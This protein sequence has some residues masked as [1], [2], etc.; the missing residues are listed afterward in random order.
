MG[1]TKRLGAVMLPALAIALFVA[2]LLV[3]TPAK[4][5]RA[6]TT[7]FENFI[8]TDDAEIQSGNPTATS[9]G[10]TYNIYNGYRILENG[11]IRIY[12]KFD[13]SKI[14]SSATIN[15]AVLKLISKYGP[16]RE[17]GFTDT[18]H[19]VDA[20]PVT[21]DSWSESTIAWD[22]APSPDLGTI[23]DSDYFQADGFL[24]GSTDRGQNSTTGQYAWYTW[25][26]KSFVAS[27]IASGDG[28]ITICLKRHDVEDA[29]ESYGW[30]YSKDSG[31]GY[32]DWLPRI[33]VSWKSDVAVSIT[34]ETHTFTTPGST[35][36][37]TVTVKNDTG[38][39]ANFNLTVENK[40]VT[41]IPSTTGNIP[42]GG[43]ADVTLTVKCPIAF[44]YQDTITV[45]ATCI[46]H[47]EFTASDTCTAVAP[48]L[49]TEADAYVIKQS[50][51]TNVGYAKTVT[52]GTE[53]SGGTMQDC[54]GYWK[55]NLSDIPNGATIDNAYFEVYTIYGG[56]NGGY[57]TGNPAVDYGDA[58]LTVTLKEVTDD[59]DEASITWNNKPDMGISLGSVVVPPTNARWYSWNVTSFVASQFSSEYNAVSFGMVSESEGINAFVPWTAKDD[60]DHWEGQQSQLIIQYTPPPGGVNVSISPLSKRGQPGSTLTYT[61]TVKNTGGGSDTYALAASDSAGWSPS[62][63]PTSTGSL[64]P[65]AQFTAT[66]S[67]PIPSD[68]QNGASHTVR[69][70]AT[71]AEASAENSCIAIADTSSRGIEVSILPISNSGRI[72]NTLTFTVTVKNTGNVSDTY[73]LARS[74]S[75]SWSPSL[76]KTSTGSLLPDAS[77]TATLSVTI[78][79]GTADGTSDK[80]TVTATSTGD[81]AVKDNAS[82]MV[83][84]ISTSTPNVWVSI[85][86]ISKS[87]APGASLTYTVTVTNTGNV[88]D[89]YTLSKTDTS[90]WNLTLPSSVADVSLSEDRQV[91]LTVEIPD[92]AAN[93]DSST[94]TVTATSSENT[95]VEYSASCTARCVEI[96]PSVTSMTVSPS[97]FALYPGYSGQVQSLTATLRDNANNPLANKTITWSA[98]SVSVNPSSGTTDALGQ[99]YV[100]YTAPAVTDE[101]SQVTITASF[102][103]D[104]LYQAS[105]ENSLGIPAT[106]V[107]KLI[108]ADNGGTVVVPV[109]GT[110]VN[111]LVVPPNALSADTTFTV[112]QAPSESISSYKIAGHIFNIGPSGTTFTTASTLTLPYDETELPIGASEGDLAIYRRTSGG[113]WELV[114]GI[115]NT[116]A[117]TV[118]VQIDHLS[119]YAVMAST[120]GVVDGGGLPLLPIG[121][122]VAVILIIA[123]IAVFIRR[124]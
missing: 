29:D 85:S 35:F 20:L 24:I 4:P 58:T 81:S 12:L 69:V 44:G 89:D 10:T 84:A 28:I 83:L 111:L 64:L 82:C 78:P 7:S 90:S 62:I 113:G 73:S 76:S 26:V 79:P 63:S 27:Q 107:T 117:N 23:L 121:V 33:E 36:N 56:E 72:G 112:S 21:N 95:E 1:K 75:A 34:P 116:T 6:S 66:L 50:P 37:Y 32:D 41:S 51:N 16:S 19:W 3:V 14:A 118:S 123:V 122:I 109:I 68:A 98:A 2:F 59:W 114:G 31:V 55:L 71:G 53:N 119:D 108:L 43:T 87:G 105:S 91:T 77:G 74:D 49:I 110:D 92:N 9:F 101:N 124:R 11:K 48:S 25:D 38:A 86:P 5:V 17:P 13:L 94:I 61:V 39:Q 100:V 65:S 57:N 70:T 99:V 96:V 93:G 52:V 80:I 102:A 8:A 60:P 40:W 106:Q 30:F 67:V 45:T 42:P 46:G 22:T 120:G 47:P 115:V 15:S 104:N 103:G 54:R 88:M 18:R 97:R